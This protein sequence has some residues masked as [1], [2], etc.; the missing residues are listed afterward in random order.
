VRCGSHTASEVGPV[1]HQRNLGALGAGGGATRVDLDHPTEAD[2]QVVDH[3][4][5]AVQAVKGPARHYWPRLATRLMTTA[6]MPVPK[7]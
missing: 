3:A 1:E 4:A 6:T 7:A 2:L 5:H